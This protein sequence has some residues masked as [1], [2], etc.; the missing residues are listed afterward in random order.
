MYVIAKLDYDVEWDFWF[1]QGEPMEFL[2]SE[3]AILEATLQ[4]V[5]G[6]KAMFAAFEITGGKFPDG[7]FDIS[8]PLA[9]AIGGELYRHE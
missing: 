1:R 7:N 2:S 9:V 6:G 3:S 8:V 5:K 4:S